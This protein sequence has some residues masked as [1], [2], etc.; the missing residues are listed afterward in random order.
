MLNIFV[1]MTNKSLNAMDKIAFAR[2]D[3]DGNGF[4]DDT[5]Y[6][7]FVA[8][9]QVNKVQPKAQEKT[10]NKGFNLEQFDPKGSINFESNGGFNATKL[11]IIA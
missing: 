1:G 9:N 3:K 4:I 11:N 7:E 5:E 10:Q 8:V 6:K 2:Y